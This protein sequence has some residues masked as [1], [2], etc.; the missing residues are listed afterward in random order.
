MIEHL[1]SPRPVAPPA[2]A[3]AQPPPYGSTAEA[4]LRTLA[5]VQVQVQVA[6]LSH[7]NLAAATAAFVREIATQLG[8]ARVSLGLCRG[9]DVELVAYSAGALPARH[10]ALAQQLVAAMAEALDQSCSL[11]LPA[12][13]EGAQ[14][15]ITLAL[16]ALLRAEPGGAACVP[17][18]AGVGASSQAVGVLCAQRQGTGSL[19][20]AELAQLEQ[21]ALLAAPVL[22]LMALNE[23]PWHRR[24]RDGLAAAAQALRDPGRHGLR[25]GTLAAGLALVGLLFVPVPTRVGGHARLEGAVQRVL[26]APADGFLGQVHVR[27]GDT[28][29]AGQVLAELA[30]QDLQVERARWESQ[31]AQHENAYSAAH[32]G[33]NRTQLVINQSRAAEAQAQLDLVNA[34]LARTHITA[35]FAGV[36]IRGDLSQQLGAPLQQG[37]ELMTLAPLDAY[38][39]MVEVDERD[40]AAV[41]LGQAGTVALSALPWQTQAIRVSRIT[42]MATVVDGRNVY[43]V[44]AELESSGAELRAGLQGSAHITTGQAPALWNAS[45]RLVQ[46]L[47]LLWWEWLG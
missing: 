33:A 4:A 23:R 19:S 35:P 32:A 20:A 30:E 40:I 16:Q 8:L 42:P 6:M 5:Q 2:A 34:R 3:V 46:A 27:P 1:A 41:Q 10:S 7:T 39:V 43:E 38:R 31:L 18:L 17:V 36:V 14:P 11:C 29:R 44:Q 37:S 13:R 25:Y 21:L 22:R 12:P 45:R 15:R 9:L 28:V 26:V 47:R 24:L